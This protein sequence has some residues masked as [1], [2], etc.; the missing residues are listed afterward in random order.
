VQVQQA[1]Q[2]AGYDLTLTAPTIPT[3]VP[4]PSS[5]SSV[6]IGLIGALALRRK[7]KK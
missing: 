1:E 5:L 6:G 2:L 4:E 7:L 3:N